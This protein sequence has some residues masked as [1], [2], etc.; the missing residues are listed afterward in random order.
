MA[1]SMC[2][3]IDTDAADSVWIYHEQS[4]LLRM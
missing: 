4:D 3:I 2:Y 1:Q